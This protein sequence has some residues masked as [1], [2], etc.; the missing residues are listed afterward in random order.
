MFRRGVLLVFVIVFLAGFVSA[1]SFTGKFYKIDINNE[2]GLDK[3]VFQLEV[4][5]KFYDLNIDRLSV[6][7]L[8]RFDVVNPGD[9][10]E[11]IGDKIGNEIRATGFNKVSRAAIREDAP[12]GSPFRGRKKVAVVKIKPDGREYD[13]P[14][15]YKWI[16]DILF[17]DYRDIRSVDRIFYEDSFET[18]K[19]CFD[20]YEMEIEDA[21]SSSGVLLQQFRN[22]RNSCAGIDEENIGLCE[23]YYHL[24]TGITDINLDSATVG[25]AYVGVVGSPSVAYSLSQDLYN[26][27]LMKI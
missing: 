27:P 11:V 16:R 12:G 7:D 4:G 23:E 17:Q 22:A 3:V 26:D 9:I 2:P 13:R 5:D 25:I 15:Y 8:Q 19:L 6:N 21:S 1:G 20:F 10:L 24:Y 18:T 14:D